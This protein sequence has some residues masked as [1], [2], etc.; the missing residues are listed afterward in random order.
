M[1]AWF[2]F[3]GYVLYIHLLHGNKEQACCVDTYW[4]GVA[5]GVGIDRSKSLGCLSIR[6]MPLRRRSG[7]V[8]SYGCTGWGG[9]PERE[10]GSAEF[11]SCELV[12]RL[13]DL[14][15]NFGGGGCVSCVRV[16]I[17]HHV[18]G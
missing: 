1:H 16:V 13:S 6:R 18:V 4:T 15:F 7:S 14:C 9:S 17:L 12:K 10:G 8:S 11:F 3:G 2:W 5:I